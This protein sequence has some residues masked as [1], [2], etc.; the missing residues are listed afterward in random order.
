MPTTQVNA[1]G[2][3]QACFYR[4]WP[5]GADCKIVKAG[6]VD[7]IAKAIV[8]TG[9]VRA[10]MAVETKAGAEIEA[11]TAC[12][13]LAWYAHDVDRIK[14][15]NLDFELATWDYELLAY[16]VGGTLITGNGA[17]ETSWNTK[18][19]GWAA[20]GPTATTQPAVA[21]ELWSR[22]AYS[23]GACSTI[24]G[25][26]T[27]IRHIFPR[28]QMQLTDRAFEEGTPG[29]MKFQGRVEANPFLAAELKNAGI[30][31]TPWIGPATVTPLATST[32]MQMFAQGTPVK[33]NAFDGG[34]TEYTFA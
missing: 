6:G 10:N 27:F 30:A 15:W 21:I 13:A 18:T 24:S 22:A 3:Y 29:Y 26:P 32:Y 14:R 1:V 5:L 20:P 19:I 4:V 28:V 9:I 17:T 8:G 2:Q 16:A 23:T 31:D 7:G 34:Y 25:A 11:T 33:G 12:G